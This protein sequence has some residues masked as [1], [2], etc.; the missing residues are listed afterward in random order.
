MIVMGFLVLPDL[1]VIL[2]LAERRAGAAGGTATAMLW[3][4][5]N[6]GGIVVALIVQGVQG[7]PALAFAVMAVIGCLAAPLALRLRT[8]LRS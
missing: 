2:E 1:P 7:S 5:G 8:Q 6:A 3:L 4:A